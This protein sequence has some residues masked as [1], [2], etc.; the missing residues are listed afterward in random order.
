MTL[1]EEKTDLLIKIFHGEEVHI[2]DIE[3]VFSKC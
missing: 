1:L 2:L 3:K